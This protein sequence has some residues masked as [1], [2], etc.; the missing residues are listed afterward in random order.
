MVNQNEISWDGSEFLFLNLKYINN[1]ILS[2]L[3][4]EL[5]ISKTL[6]IIK[7]LFNCIKI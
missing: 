6:K 4:V 3:R 1:K 2:R 5:N 7:K